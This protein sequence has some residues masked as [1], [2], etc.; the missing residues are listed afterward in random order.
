MGNIEHHLRAISSSLHSPAANTNQSSVTPSPTAGISPESQGRDPDTP[1]EGS[2]SFT[3]H[4]I[5]ASGFVEN[6]VT[7]MD[8]TSLGSDMRSALSALQK[9]VTTQN[10]WVGAQIRFSNQKNLPHGGFR[11]LPMPPM[12]LVLRILQE[13]KGKCANHGFTAHYSPPQF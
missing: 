8:P 1:F 12:S 4:A 2:S 3:A 9:I 5:F 7:G 13:L 10:H 11:A 6:A